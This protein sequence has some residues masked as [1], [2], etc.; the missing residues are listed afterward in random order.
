MTEGRRSNK[1]IET[2]MF[3]LLDFLSLTGTIVP[4]WKRLWSVGPFGD[5][6]TKK[7]KLERCLLAS[8]SNTYCRYYNFATAEWEL[9]KGNNLSEATGTVHDAILHET[10][11]SE[12]SHSTY[13][14][15]TAKKNLVDIVSEATSLASREYGQNGRET[16]F[17]VLTNLPW[18]RLL[19]EVE[20]NPG[21]TKVSWMIEDKSKGQFAL[22]EL[23]EMPEF[24]PSTQGNIQL[25]F[26]FAVMLMF[27]HV[28]TLGFSKGATRELISQSELEKQEVVFK[29]TVQVPSKSIPDRRPRRADL[30][31]SLD[32]LCISKEPR[33]PRK[34]RIRLDLTLDDSEPGC[35]LS[36]DQAYISPAAA[37]LAYVTLSSTFK[38]AFLMEELRA[39]CKMH[40]SFRSG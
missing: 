5:P 27:G 11:V 30:G 13:D 21:P 25:S 17:E 18:W 29:E 26:E 22:K 28:K 15:P 6:T 7:G 10:V 31:S 38:I 8:M 2:F 40:I 14:V 34:S 3:R 37:S 20:R 4:K 33:P 24:Y 16:N 23:L 19:T 32:P 1:R 9:L 39:G 35:S 12:T 36:D